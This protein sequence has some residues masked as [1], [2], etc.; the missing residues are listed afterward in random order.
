M[1]IQFERNALYEEPALRWSFR[2]QQG[3]MLL[4]P[5]NSFRFRFSSGTWRRGVAIASALLYAAENR[6]FKIIKSD[7]PSEIYLEKFGAKVSIN[8]SEKFKDEYRQVKNPSELEILLGP[9]DI[10]FHQES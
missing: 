2:E 1:A 7:D 4:L 5:D 8:L 3:L 6:G 10:R 9:G